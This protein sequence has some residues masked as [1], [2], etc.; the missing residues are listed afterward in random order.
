[1]NPL[2]PWFVTMGL[3]ATALMLAGL[4]LSFVLQ[5][6]R[7]LTASSVLSATLVGLLALPVLAALLPGLPVPVP[8]MS[9]WQPAVAVGP[10]ATVEH[11][12][13][14]ASSDSRPRWSSGERLPTHSPDFDV[15]IPPDSARSP[16]DTGRPNRR[17]PQSTAEFSTKVSAH[18]SPAAAPPARGWRDLTAAA[19][20][21]GVII[22]ALRFLRG[23]QA[24]R[25]L[26]ESSVPVEGSWL[27][28]LASMRARLGLSRRVELLCSGE[29]QIPL[30]IGWRRPAV[31]IPDSILES[32]TP[33]QEAVLLHELA[34]IRRHDFVDVV[35]L[36]IVQMLYW[37]HPLAWVMG[38]LARNLRERACDDACVYWMGA[39]E[40]Y[41]SALLEI[42]RRTIVS[43][44]LAIGLA[45]VHPSRLAQRLTRID[46]SAGNRR[47]TP[48]A[49][50]QSA[51]YC[52][53][54]AVAA[55]TVAVQ[56]VPRRAAAEASRRGENAT[57]AAAVAQPQGAAAVVPAALLPDPA[58]PLPLYERLQTGVENLG[59]VPEGLAAIIGSSRLRHWSYVHSVAWSPDGSLLGS[60]GGDGCLRLWNPDT[61]ELVRRFKSEPAWPGGATHITSV[62]FEPSGQRVAVG[63]G[64][65]AVRVWDI[66]TGV[67]T[68]FL[69]DDSE[70][71]K[72]AWHPAEPLLATG[73]QQIARLWDLET[74]KIVRTLEPRDPAFKRQ[75]TTDMVHVAFTADGR[76]VLVGHPD[77][78][79]RSWDVVTGEVVRTIA[80]HE[81]VIQALAIDAQRDRLATGGREGQVRLWQLSTGK[82][83]R[84]IQA[85]PEYVQG[86]AFHPR[87]DALYSAGLDGLVRK[88]DLKTGEQSLELVASRYIGPSAVAM[89]PSRELIATAGHAARLWNADTGT[90]LLESAG[91]LGGVQALRFTPDGSRLIT[92][93]N[94]AT[95]RVWDANK[96]SQLARIELKS[97]AAAMEVTP[98]GRSL[99]TIDHHHGNIHFR[100]LDDGRVERSFGAGS[101]TS[102]EQIAVS[103][104]GKWLAANVNERGERGT[105][106]LWNLATN[107]PHGRLEAHHG[108]P[109][110][111][112]DGSRLLVVG[113]EY[114]PG[115]GQKSQ[116]SVWDVA[117]LQKVLSLPDVQGLVSI[118][119][120]ALAPDGTT[121]VIA[122]TA[123]DKDQKS[124][125]RLAFWDWNRNETR[126]VVEMRNHRPDS[127]AI[128][129]D[130]RS[131]FTVAPRDGEVRLWDLRDGSLR[132]TIQLCAGGHW[133]IGPAAFSADSRQVAVA[134]GNGAVYILDVQSPAP[135]VAVRVSVP[136]PDEPA[137]V[138][139]WNA[140]IGRPAPE[141]QAEGWLYGEATTAEALRGKW[142]ALYFWTSAYSEQDMP[143]WM[144]LQQRLGANA[145]TIVVV[146][147]NW[148]DSIDVPRK[149]FEARSREWWGGKPLP[150]RVLVDKQRPNQIPGTQ[151]ETG[152]ATFA[153]YRVMNAVRGYRTES[154]GL[155]I[156]PDGLIRQSLPNRPDRST[157]RELEKLIGARAEGPTEAAALPATNSGTAV[158]A[159]PN[160][161][162]LEETE[163][164]E[165]IRPREFFRVADIRRLDPE[166]G[167]PVLLHGPK[168]NDGD[169]AR[170]DAKSRVVELAIHNTSVRGT[171]LQHLA[172]LPKLRKLA[173]LGPWCTDAVLDSLPE[174]PELTSLTLIECTTTDE[175]LKVLAKFKGLEELTLHFVQADQGLEHLQQVPGLNRLSLENTRLTD[176]GLQKLAAVPRLKHLSLNNLPEITDDGLAVLRD[177]PELES[178]YCEELTARGSGLAHL[179]VATNLKELSL[180]GTGVND[181]WLHGLKSLRNV[182]WLQLH[183]TKITGS[184][185]VAIRE[186]GKV[187]DAYLPFNQIDDAGVEHLAELYRLRQLGL[188]GNP[189]G[190]EGI[191]RLKDALPDTHVQSGR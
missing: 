65:N 93:G 11:D 111:S 158:A 175:S 26:R 38:H 123:Y 6:R 132:Q 37:C 129:P 146:S 119:A 48:S 34:H 1:M 69:N 33:Q 10:V 12:R 101:N 172:S 179:A 81:T 46:Q 110:F 168:I 109:Y 181:V 124:H 72:V 169:F 32:T 82:G 161:A 116:V 62:A 171:G 112:A 147:P 185:L 23:L 83:L 189:I 68:R 57:G 126:L 125:S 92:A 144:E 85:H 96:R 102:S 173:L 59:Q 154:L 53:L 114:Q 187:K 8:E 145:P 67:E 31:I 138:D 41:R 190:D 134:M 76:Q 166:R 5:R 64:T 86:L 97:P 27:D 191:K 165:W 63:I 178:F 39:V 80:A 52:L 87:Q 56:F 36:Q 164:V 74:G 136:R 153:A 42:A 45:M 3:R 120:S 104:D 40:P 180:V 162:R 106:T 107:A 44:P 160:G 24:V 13:S 15:A 183:K 71:L 25:R 149:A 89:H 21:T 182:E 99:V 127:L 163:A 78:S 47:C 184:G 117:S 30:T 113:S 77:G 157:L 54:F 50:L 137:P 118:G 95:L 143:A 61:G 2:S 28:C 29:I 16:R 19:Y 108:K 4:G 151:I 115:S 141:F 18:I 177:L 17:P 142:V 150:F 66:R 121:L 90:P 55:L 176:A 122:G 167:G 133:A 22:L 139:P 51:V 152:G 131:V 100:S 105:L 128:A 174:L 79:L 84:D 91:H 73:G 156:G 60:I 186:W 170:F 7:P 188:Q 35:L 43:P 49:P 20:A 130:G 148:G 14:L 9:V 140:L 155:L 94:D 98:D 75:F 159:A 58:E 103:P 70:V 88:W 135:E